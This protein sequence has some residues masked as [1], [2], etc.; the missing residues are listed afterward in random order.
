MRIVHTFLS[1]SMAYNVFLYYT[2]ERRTNEQKEKKIHI[3]RS[4][5]RLLVSLTHSLSSKYLKIL[6]TLSLWWVVLGSRAFWLSVLLAHSPRFVFRAPSSFFGIVI[7]VLHTTV[8]SWS[9]KHTCTRYSTRR[10]KRA[11]LQVRMWMRLRER[12]RDWAVRISAA[13]RTK[14]NEKER[15]HVDDDDDNGVALKACV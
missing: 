14:E 7:D 8:R 5:A 2:P 9:K 10:E 4:F 11:D 1:F 6:H 13:I 3:A 12:V 15:N